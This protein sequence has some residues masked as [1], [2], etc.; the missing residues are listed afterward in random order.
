MAEVFDCLTKKETI[1]LRA[2][3][4]QKALLRRAAEATDQSLA[5]FVR[6]SAVEQAERVLAERHW[7]VATDEQRDE[8]IS[9]L[10]ASPS[11]AHHFDQLFSRPSRFSRDTD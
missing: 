10:D 11:V 1:S 3:E 5:G 7:F 4:R 2:T 8:F 6:G 9:E